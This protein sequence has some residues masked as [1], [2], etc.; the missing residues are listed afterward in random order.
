MFSLI[1][2]P[3]SREAL[4]SLVTVATGRGA[5]SSALGSRNLRCDEGDR[6]QDKA[7]SVR[8][9][10]FDPLRPLLD[11][12]PNGPIRPFSV[13]QL[14]IRNGSSCSIP[15]LGPTRL[16]TQ[17]GTGPPFPICSTCDARASKAIIT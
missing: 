8:M 16:V 4:A 11:A 15:D 14:R 2:A 7:R 5:A 6:C 12:A 13:T 10:G 1:T 3:W 9:A 17:P